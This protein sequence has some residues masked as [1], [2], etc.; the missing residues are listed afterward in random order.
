VSFT[1]LPLY[2]G[3]RVLNTHWLGGWVGH[4]DDL[5]DVEKITFLILP[6]RAHKR[7]PTF[8]SNCR[9]N[10]GLITRGSTIDHRTSWCKSRII[11]A[12]PLYIFIHSD[13]IS[14]PT[15]YALTLYVLREFEF[16]LLFREYKLKRQ[17]TSPG[18]MESVTEKYVGA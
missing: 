9:I 1:P 13:F 10:K 17:E 16:R 12:H 5:D 18:K 6:G 14:T 11:T 8:H 2:P 4:T 3:E 15:R 7:S